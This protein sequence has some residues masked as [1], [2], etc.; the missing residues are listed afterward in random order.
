MQQKG[1][2]HFEMFFECIVMV[3][4]ICHITTINKEGVKIVNSNAITNFTSMFHKHQTVFYLRCYTL[5]K[6]KKTKKTNFMAPFYGWGTSTSR[7]VPPRGGSL[8]FT[9]KFPDILGTH[10]TNLE[11]MKD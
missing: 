8:L 7:L 10:F 3:D 6:L 4:K 1:I 9:T 5:I 2:V 11:R